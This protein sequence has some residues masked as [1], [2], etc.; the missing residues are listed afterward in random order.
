MGNR[1]GTEKPSDRLPEGYYH[2]WDRSRWYFIDNEGYA[3][4]A[5]ARTQEI[6]ERVPYRALLIVARSLTSGVP[7]E[8]CRENLK[9]GS[10]VEILIK[11]E[12][13]IGVVRC[14]EYGRPVY[15]NQTLQGAI[16]AWDDVKYRVAAY[17]TM[18]EVVFSQDTTSICSPG[19][20]LK[21]AP[22]AI[23]WSWDSVYRVD[24][25]P[26]KIGFIA[27]CGVTLKSP[28]RVT[29]II[30]GDPHIGPTV[31]FEKFRAA[32]DQK[33]EYLPVDL[34][35]GGQL[36]VKCTDGYW[37]MAYIDEVRPDWYFTVTCEDGTVVPPLS[38]TTEDIAVYGSRYADRPPRIP[39]K[40]EPAL[41]T[42]AVMPTAPTVAVM[43]TAPPVAVMPPA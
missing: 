7:P 43:P 32:V 37:R 34:K 11:N 24:G 39:V 19:T 25:I 12:W 1:A 4:P 6:V 29:L 5:W 35:R 14:R 15:G 31:S 28:R 21:W 20:N 22:E 18:K 8:G 16:K 38:Y 42:V 2:N 23:T 26:Y 27:A 10:K 30:K 17:D 13:Q 36:D 33:E 41:P 40:N 9:K 3:V